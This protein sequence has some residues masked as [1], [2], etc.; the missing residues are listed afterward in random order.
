MGSVRSLDDSRLIKQI[1]ECKVLLDGAIAY[2]KGEKPSGYF[3]HPVAQHYKDYPELLLWYGYCCCLEYSTR[4]KYSGCHS[5]LL[6]FDNLLRQTDISKIFKV[7]KDCPKIYVEGRKNTPQCI[8]ETQ[9]TKV[10]V[11]FKNKLKDKWQKDIDK[12]RPPK[13]TNRGMPEW[14]KGERYGT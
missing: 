1:L 11:L 13:W 2:K 4:F 3:K 9:E 7:S 8:R 10:Y 14:A 6:Y 12:G 5:Y